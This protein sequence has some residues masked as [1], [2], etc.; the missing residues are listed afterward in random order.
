M[1]QPQ[2]KAARHPKNVTAKRDLLSSPHDR[3]PLISLSIGITARRQ[4]R[5]P[6]AQRACH[7]ARERYRARYGPEDVG[8]LVSRGE[9]ALVLADLGRP[10]AAE[11]ELRAVTKTARRALGDAHPATMALRD[12]LT[13]VQHHTGRI[14]ETEAL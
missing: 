11:E 1:E 7:D 4:G 6:L 13:P 8:T 2:R 12:S 10:A 14:P 3:P 9:L 5:Y